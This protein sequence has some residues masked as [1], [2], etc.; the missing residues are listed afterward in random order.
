MR[1]GEEPQANHFSLDSW[2]S[3]GHPLNKA[4][5]YSF[6]L[7]KKRELDALTIYKFEGKRQ[8]CLAHSHWHWFQYG[9]WR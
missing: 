3:W 6:K 2:A 4:I 1:N 7:R 5:V 8:Q 9:F